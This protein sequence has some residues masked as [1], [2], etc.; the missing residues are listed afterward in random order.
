MNES[1]NVITRNIS[2]YPDQEA[3]IV[4]FARESGLESV[5][6]A[7]R[8]IINDWVNLKRAEIATAAPVE[9]RAA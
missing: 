9:A 7:L 4:Q 6:A 8:F 5:S 3:V 1:P 2:I